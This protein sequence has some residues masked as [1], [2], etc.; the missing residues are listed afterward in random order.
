MIERPEPARAVAQEAMLRRLRV[1]DRRVEPVDDVGRGVARAVAGP[2]QRPR[3]RRVVAARHGGQP[4]RPVHHAGP[5]ELVEGTEG[6]G[7]GADA[8]AGAAHA[9]V[10]RWRQ[11]THRDRLVR[12]RDRRRRLVAPGDGEQADGGD[13]EQTDAVGE[14]LQPGQRR[15]QRRRDEVV[16]I[17]EAA[18]VGAEG[19]STS[20]CSRRRRA[21]P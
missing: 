12:P 2:G 18:L 3:R 13:A 6:E 17:G 5:L 19:D 15:H 7:R 10:G 14:H 11:L 20:P 21:P 16:G 4:A 9:E 8:S 1:R